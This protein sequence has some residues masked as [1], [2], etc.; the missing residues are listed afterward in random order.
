MR[1][2]RENITDVFWS[3]LIQAVEDGEEILLVKAGVPFARLA[4]LETKRQKRELGYD[5]GLPFR[6][7]PDFDTF[8]P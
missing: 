1:T 7:A 5:E 8:I 6:I 4:P 2:S 3:S